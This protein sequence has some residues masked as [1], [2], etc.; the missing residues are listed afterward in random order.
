MKN[1]ERKLSRQLSIVEFL[2]RANDSSEA[3]M[4]EFLRLEMNDSFLAKELLETFYSF[5]LRIREHLEN[6][7]DWLDYYKRSL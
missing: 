3:L 6:Q 4:S 1:Q 2:E 5:K 7:K